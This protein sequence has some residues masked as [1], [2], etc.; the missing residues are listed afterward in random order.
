VGADAL[1]TD[2]E[3]LIVVRNAG[4]EVATLKGNTCFAVAA[5]ATRICEAIV[6]DERATLVA[7]SLMSGQYGLHDVSL[8]TP[9]FVGC[10][11]VESVMELHLNPTEQ[12]ALEASAAILQQAYAKL[13]NS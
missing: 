12:K 11:S 6:R 3:L 7:S 10:G 2:E 5:C 13:R 9:C 4:P 1:P 8:S